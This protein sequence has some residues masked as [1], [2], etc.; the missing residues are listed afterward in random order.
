M[1]RTTANPG[2]LKRGIC[3][4]YAKAQWDTFRAEGATTLEP[5]ATPWVSIIFY[6]LSPVGAVPVYQ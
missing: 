6:L 1:I 3:L 4:A 5:R 2:T